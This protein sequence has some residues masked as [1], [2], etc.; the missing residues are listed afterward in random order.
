MNPPAPH[1]RALL[2]T[3]SLG[4]TTSL[5][6]HNDDD[7]HSGN[8]RGDKIVANSWCVKLLMVK[9]QDRR[10]FTDRCRV[11]G[12]PADQK[13]R[14]VYSTEAEPR[15]SCIRTPSPLVVRG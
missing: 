3:R 2:I 10:Q 6:S 4:A 8:E 14:Q 1:T 13:P 11:A 9:R 5:S 7:R 12:L 15:H